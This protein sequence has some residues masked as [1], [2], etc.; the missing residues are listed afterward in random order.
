MFKLLI[1]LG[2]LACLW[3]FVL[4]RAG[5][6][7]SAAEQAFPPLGQI[8]E[9]DGH[10]VHALVMGAKVGTAPDVV[11]LHGSGGN[12]RD[13]TSSIAPVLAENYRVILIDRP[14]HG[15]TDRIN[16]TGA[17]LEQQSMLLAATARQLGAANPIVVGHSFG[18]AVALD[19]AVHEPESIAALVLL[20]APSNPWS[21]GVSRF[22]RL[23]SHWVTAP[24]LN[25]LIT[26]FVPRSR[27]KTGVAEVFEP[28]PVPEGYLDEF[29]A[30]LTLRRD[31]L[32]ANALQRRDLLPQI[33][34]MIPGYGTIFVPTEILH[35]TEDDIV[36]LSIHS[37]LLVDQIPEAALTRLQGIGHMPHHTAPNQV[38]EAIHRAAVRAGL[39]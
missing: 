9:V 34:A 32:R 16:T 7:E 1:F 23:T 33:E 17:T 21:T 30:A 38:I 3:A 10:K 11:L 6:R 18:G 20:A 5:A 15:F 14:G 25:P 31:A 35:G 39:R 24:I 4:V 2:F 29:G 12:I 8:I 27:V 28:D 36:G 19:W 37:E 26:A 13:L 22:Y